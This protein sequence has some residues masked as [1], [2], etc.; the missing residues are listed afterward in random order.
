MMGHFSPGLSEEGGTQSGRDSQEAVN[1]GD[2]L[3]IVPRNDL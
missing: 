1:E 2:G 3:Q